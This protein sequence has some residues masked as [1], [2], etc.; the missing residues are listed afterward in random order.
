VTGF[1]DTFP[2]AT[3][4]LILCFFASLPVPRALGGSRAA[5]APE[6]AA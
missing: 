4:F 2:M 5:A 6:G 3:G 1:T